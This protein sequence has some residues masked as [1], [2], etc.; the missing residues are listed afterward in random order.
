MTVNPVARG[1]SKRFDASRAVRYLAKRGC[2]TRLVVPGSAAEATAAAREAGERGDDLLF[3]VGGDGSVR[4]AAKGLAGFETA[5][6]AVPAGTVN[7]WAREAG[8]PPGVRTAID[9]HLAGQ[10]VHMDLGRA[11][12]ECFLLMAGIGWDAEIAGRV[13]KR[14][15][16]ATGDIA[17][18]LQ[19]ALMAPG[20]RARQAR[21]VTP[22]GVV[23]D[24][25]AWMVLSNTRLYGGK[26]HLT[27]EATLDDGLL[28][29]LAMSPGGLID[30]VRIAG[31]LLAG[32]HGDPRIHNLRVPELRLE[33]RGFAVQ[34]D[35]DYAGETPMTFH[36][37]QRALLVSVPAGP[38]AAIFGAEH[39]D[40]RKP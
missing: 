37:D 19:G 12:G 3:V 30:T 11:D 10:S 40:R 34:L 22:D 13:S 8:I 16:Q 26:I 21:W 1:V 9:S 23:E 33:T 35:G 5:L 27:P 17:Y 20:L 24:S 38:L 28:D 7:I 39:R 32:R 18:M 29:V 6:A 15:K 2:E 14:L 31:K 36:I 4:D 25:L